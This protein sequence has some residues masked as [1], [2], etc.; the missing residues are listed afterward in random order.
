MAILTFHGLRCPKVIIRG[1]QE[2]R[3]AGLRVVRAIVRLFP[4]Y[5]R[6]KN[7]IILAARVRIDDKKLTFSIPGNKVNNT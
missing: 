4:R 6:Q 3:V 1:E 2:L 5:Y 7:A